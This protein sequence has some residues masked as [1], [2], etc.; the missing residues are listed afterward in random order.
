MPIKVVKKD[1]VREPFDL[2]K[3]RQGLAKACWKRPIKDEDVETLI[4]KIESFVYDNLDVEIESQDLG[5][6]LMDGLRELD[7]VAF[8]RFASVY[9]RFEDVN[10]FVDELQPILKERMEK[11]QGGRTATKRS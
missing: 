4:T 7:D 11:I 10:D 9:R 1:G 5:E 6:M 2:Q 3:I 8:V